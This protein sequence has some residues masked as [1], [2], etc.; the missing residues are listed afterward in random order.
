MSKLLNIITSGEVSVRDAALAAA[1]ERLS[2]DELLAECEALDEFRRKADNLYERVRALFF[3][4][5][6]H[7]FHLPP[8]LPANRIGRIPFEGH[9][10]LLNR[11]SSEAIDTFLVAVSEHGAGD[12]LSSALASAYHE[13]AFQTLANQVRKSVRTVRGNQ[14]MFRM[15]HPA[16]HPL[17]IAGDLLV[18]AP[19]GSRAILR[20][21]TPVRMDLSHSGWSDIFFL[22]M[23]YPEGARVLNVSVDLGVHGRDPEPRPPIEAYLRVID[24][25]VLVLTSVDLRATTRIDNLGEVFDFAKDYLGLLKAAVIAAGVMPPG[26]EGSGQKLESLLER[27]VGPGK[28][29]ELISSVNGIPKGSRLAVSTNLL[30][31]LI[32]VLMR[33][34]GQTA[35]LT[36]ALQ[37]NERRLVLARAI[38][39]EWLGGSG[40]GWQ[41]S[42]GVWPGIK[43]ISGQAAAQADPEFGVSRGRLMPTHHVFGEEEI[44]AS[45]RQALQDSLVLV[46]GG[47]AQNVGP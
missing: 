1:C 41:D 46:H 2:L 24:E 10:H 25:P 26:I 17:R 12:S 16:D 27:V 21:Q 23:D 32:G 6:V 34:T 7:R 37:E 35:S 9:E 11:R 31:A 38:L 13:L 15:G 39:G 19:N 14:W 3:L 40:G 20:E 42:G 18:T 33:A 5:A 29:L 44:P 43:L 28:G 47:M 4:Y 8:R 30:A 22:G 36:G 45:A